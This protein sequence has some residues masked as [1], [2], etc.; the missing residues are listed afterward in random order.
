MFIKFVSFYLTS[1][2]IYLDHISNS[3]KYTILRM[4]IQKH[5]MNKMA[6][7]K[8]KMGDHSMPKEKPT[9]VYPHPNDQ[10]LYVVNNGTD[11][12]VEVDVKKW[13]I[14]RRF[15]TDK[16]P[17]NCEVSRDGKKMVVLSLIHI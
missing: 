1:C 15:Q 6:G 14:T 2:V 13:M 10:F 17:Y 12:V 3:S 16:G 9:W 8:H 5:D 4:H 11:E 7:M